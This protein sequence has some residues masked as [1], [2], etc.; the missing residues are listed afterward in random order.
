MATVCPSVRLCV[1][2]QG[3][4]TGRRLANLFEG[5]R[6]KCLNFEKKILSHAHGNFVEQNSVMEPSALT[7]NHSI[8]IINAYYN[9]ITNGQ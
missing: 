9:C 5:A 4:G 1:C 8:I 7:I 6:P 3:S 2:D